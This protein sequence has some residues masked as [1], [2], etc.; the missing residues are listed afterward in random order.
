M[1]YKSTASKD[2]FAFPGPRGGVLGALLL[3]M[4]ILLIPRESCALI[5][6]GTDLSYQQ[7][8][9]V[10][11]GVTSSTVQERFSFYFNLNS[12]PSSR[13]SFAGI[14][15]FDVLQNNIN[16]G[17]KSLELQPNVDIRISSSAVQLG[18]GYRQ[19]TRNE[20]VIA[21]VSASSLRSDSDDWYVDSTIRA[22]KLPTLRVR[23]SVTDQSQTTD[24]V[25]TS[26]SG[27][28]DLQSS[29]NYKLGPL[30]IN[31]D[32]RTQTTD[33]KITG[34]I[35]DSSQITGQA[36]LNQKIGSK[37]DLGLRDNY[38]RSDSK[39][40]DNTV[41]SKLYSNISEARIIYN[42]FAGMSLNSTYSYRISDDT[43]SGAGKTTETNWFSAFNY[44][45]PKYLRLYG[46]YLT[47]NTDS[48]TTKAVNNTT[49]A[50]MNFANMFGRY[51]FTARYERR[52]NSV[53]TDLAGSPSTT[54]KNTSD[55]LDWILSARI[56]NYLV[57]ALSESYTGTTDDNGNTANNRF[58]LK[59]DVG[60]I[61]NVTLNPYFDYNLATAAD[62]SQTTTK[63][64]VLP[65]SFRVML[66][67]RLEFSITDNFR[68]SSSESATLVNT[69]QS[70]NAV[71][72]LN[73]LR[74]FPGTVI[75][76]D[77][78]FSTSS[79]N[80]GSATNT[81]EYTLR[82]NWNK[83]PHTAAANIRY[84][85]GTNTPATTSVSFLYGLLVKLRKLQLGFQARYDYSI[86]MSSV[87]SS[88][89]TV[90][91]LL[92]LKK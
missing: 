24:G 38:N 53:A 76:G 92:N 42:P 4:A 62:G 69:S 82:V 1:R 63:E 15:K 59:A 84:Q 77:A 33:D 16:P 70:N 34:I 47:L 67:Q 26:K 48:P 75:G 60:P 13:L 6:Y 54:T 51:S 31:A 11:G 22:G 36:T 27:T 79:S 49:I 71:V 50:G 81:S 40:S 35:T 52:I 85:T 8:D 29:V 64:L 78:S 43:T 32:Y 73:L 91:M 57:L 28:K 39:N 45:L 83:A 5:N 25:A 18:V 65:A 37:V 87:K 44:A 88:T 74:P 72:R 17:S 23:Y 12:R 19:I 55:N 20:T 30:F 9:V 7:N 2:S 61:K 86:V 90:Y 21:G 41:N 68:W 58:R 56:K 89:Q 3:F 80:G 66:H 10:N 14:L 46:S